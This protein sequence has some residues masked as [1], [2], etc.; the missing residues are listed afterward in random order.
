MD[1]TRNADMNGGCSEDAVCTVVERQPVCACNAGYDGDGFVVW[2]LTGVL[3][4][5]QLRA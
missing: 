4:A 2:T 5:G 1:L 3:R